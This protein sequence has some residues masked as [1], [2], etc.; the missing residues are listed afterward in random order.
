M[1]DLCNTWDA[2]TGDCLTCY[3]GYKISNGGCVIDN[4]GAGETCPY[5]SVKINGQCKAVSDLCSTWDE[6][7]ADCTSCY[8]GYKL[9]NGYCIVDNGQGN[10]TQD[11]PPRTV[12]IDGQ[13]KAVSDLC[14]TWSLTTAE[15]LSCY[16]GYTLT[17]GVCKV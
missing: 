7:T 17:G 3:G 14:K 15:C 8:G 10:T 16:D 6:T 13:C 12:K 5:R 11:C 9:N 2:T 4:G 1:S